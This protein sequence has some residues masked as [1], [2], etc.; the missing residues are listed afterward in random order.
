MTS[1]N[2][3]ASHDALQFGG[4]VWFRSGEQA[5][6]GTQRIALLAAIGETGSITGAAKAI[7]MSY[8][9]AWDAVDA[10][11][12]LAGET[13]VIRSTG[14]KGGGGTTL[15]PRALTLIDTFRAVER[16]HRLFLERA[17]VAIAGFSDDWQ[18]IGRIGMKT[19]ARNQWYGKVSAIQRGTVNDEVSLAL[20]G[21][22]SVVAVVT[23]ESTETLG[24]AVG[25][26]AVALVKASSVLLVA[27]DGTAER[28]STR[29]RL[30]G[31]VSAVQ[32]GAVNAEVSLTLEGGAVVTAVVTNESVAELGIA[33]GQALV[34][35]FKASSVIL[36]VTA[37]A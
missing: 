17:G 18:L 6:G 32:R 26:E 7:G 25:G 21:G 27:D 3:D 22:Q 28:L 31:T 13:L 30:R 36:G 14:G 5:L 11:N 16:E 8:K 34:A 19:S 9:A 12:N 37:L 33:E 24:L 35:A 15:T 10:M 2:N 20:P 29:N 23:H 1:D 4:S